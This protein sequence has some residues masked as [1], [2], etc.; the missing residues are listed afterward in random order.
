MC[1][2]KSKNKETAIAYVEKKFD[3]KL[4]VSKEK[5]AGLVNEGALLVPNKLLA[6]A[7]D[8]YEVW[9]QPKKRDGTLG[10]LRKQKV[11]FVHSFCPH[12]GVKYVQ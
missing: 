5:G 8:E 10:N 2:C 11:P 4:Q 6:V 1:D 7:F 12:C 3:G 9:V